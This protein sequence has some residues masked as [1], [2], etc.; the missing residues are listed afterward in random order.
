MTD[1][2]ADPRLSVVLACLDAADTIGDQLDALAAQDCPVPWELLV[3]DN[4]STDGTQELVGRY[5]PSRPH[6]RLIDAGD[7]RGS[8]PA[9]NVGARL[10]RG[11]WLAFCDADDVVASTWLAAMA[12]ALDRHEFVAGRFEATLLNAPWVRRS[13]PVQQQEGLQSADGPPHLPHCGACNMG[14]HRDRFLAVGGF[15]P[16]IRV[17]ED[18][19]FSWRV[20]LAGARLVFDPDVVVHMRLR[21]S[22][23]GMYRQGFT[24]GAA[25]GVLAARYGDG[26][27]GAAQAP[28]PPRRPGARWRGLLRVAGP[29]IRRPGRGSLGYVLWQVGWHKG[30]AGGVPGGAGSN[31]GARS[32][33]TAGTTDREV[34]DVMS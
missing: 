23:R 3:C 17:L 32:S 15:D 27:P 12:A 14:I 6:W 21:D 30:K 25:A 33:S 28:A 1:T 22:L 11:E 4:G 16:Q 26:R 7:L 24:Y 29:V 34:K 9:R 13:R 18:T 2:H 8:G 5:L 19:D 20:Q 31:S 10:G